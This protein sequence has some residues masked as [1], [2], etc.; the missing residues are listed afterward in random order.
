MNIYV[1]L[2]LEIKLEAGTFI[3]RIE[4]VDEEVLGPYEIQECK[5][6]IQTLT[7]KTIARGYFTRVKRR[8]DDRVILS[9]GGSVT[10]MF[11][12]ERV[13]RRQV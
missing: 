12:M 8:D 9:N 13:D 6:V 11:L 2:I 7:D 4:Y 3:P 10:K 5:D 1:V